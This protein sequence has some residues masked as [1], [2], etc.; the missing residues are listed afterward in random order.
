MPDYAIHPA[1]ELNDANFKR[2]YSTYRTA[3]DG[4]LFSRVLGDPSIWQLCSTSRQR[5]IYR[6]WTATELAALDITM[7]AHVRPE[8]ALDPITINDTCLA[9]LSWT[10]AIEDFSFS[11]TR[12]ASRNVPS[13][14]TSSD[15]ELTNLEAIRER[16]FGLLQIGLRARDQRLAGCSRMSPQRR[17][18]AGT[19]R[20]LRRN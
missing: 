10:R 4:V 15:G 11:E 16:L 5:K 7:K 18:W 8:I 13:D 6:A 20:S 12:V 9:L 2:A 1:A 14:S 17:S 3:S 19:T